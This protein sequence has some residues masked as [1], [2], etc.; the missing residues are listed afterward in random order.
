MFYVYRPWITA[1][2]PESIITIINAKTLLLTMLRSSYTVNFPF[3]DLATNKPILR[4]SQKN[5]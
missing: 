4:I 2:A 3:V 1:M 5:A